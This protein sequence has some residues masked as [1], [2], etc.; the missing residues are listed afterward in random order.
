MGSETTGW[1]S[2][3]RYKRGLQSYG[4]SKTNWVDDK[5]KDELKFN[6]LNLV[7]F[8]RLKNCSDNK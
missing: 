2:I 6:L 7:F 4:S 1:G 8:D 3:Y 5:A